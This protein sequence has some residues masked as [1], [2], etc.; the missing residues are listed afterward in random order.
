MQ[1]P[2]IFLGKLRRLALI[3]RVLKADITVPSVVRDEVLA[4][5]ARSLG[6]P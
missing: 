5:S 4:P 1:A 3:R 2:L 6:I